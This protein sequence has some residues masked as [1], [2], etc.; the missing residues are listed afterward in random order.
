MSNFKLVIVGGVAGGA[1]AAARARRRC[2]ACDIVVFE[3]GPHVSFANCG[4]PYFVGGEIVHQ[5]SLLLQTPETLRARFNLDVR[6]RTEVVAIDREARAVHVREL[7]SGRTYSQPFDALILSTGASPL[8]P[9]IPGIDRP[10]HFTVRNIPDVEQINAWV[11]T[12]TADRAVVVGGGYIGLEMA[13]QLRRRG[14]TV[15]VVEALPQVMAPL[16]ADMAAWLHAELAANGVALHLGNPVAAFDDP[17]P[18]E[19]ARASVVVLKNGQRFAADL[20]V[21]GLGVR[22]EVSLARNAGLELGS[23]GGIRVNAH[24]QTSDPRIWAVGDAVEVRDRIT[25]MWNVI[26]LAGPANR[27]GRVAA[28]NIFGRSSTYEGTWGTAVLRLFDLTAACTG[29]NERSLRKANLPFQVLHLHPGPHAGYYPGAD[30]IAI[31]LLFAPDTGRILGAQ[32]VGAEGVDKRID[33]LATALQ[34]GM[35]VHQLVDLELAYAPPFGSAKDPVNLAGMASQN[36]LSGDVAFAQWHEI[37]HVVPSNTLILDVRRPDEVAQGVI[38]GSVHVP[39]DLLRSKL[40]QL[41]RDREIVVHCQSGQRSYFACRI[42][43]QHGFRVRNLVGGYRTWRINSSP[44][45]P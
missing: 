29:A 30:P 32:A 13:E 2:E 21:L 33:V 35:T 7:E 16:D 25:G 14:L 28:D 34:G 15:T 17:R 5:D 23:L 22:P 27:Q 11:G 18:D 41:P 4:L 9:P 31:K 24:L 20:V 19:S 39:L 40:D 3:R 37:A 36:A 6:V 26:P 8:K 1:S 42:L 45:A 43:A 38:P 44:A 10:G 12:R